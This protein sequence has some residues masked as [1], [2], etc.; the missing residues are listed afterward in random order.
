MMDQQRKWRGYNF[1]EEIISRV[2]WK[3]AICGKDHCLHS[4]EQVSIVSIR[5]YMNCQMNSSTRTSSRNAPLTNKQLPVLKIGI[6]ALGFR[7][8]KHLNALQQKKRELEAP[9]VG[10]SMHLCRKSVAALYRS[11]EIYP[12]L[13]SG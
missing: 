12:L 6:S 3:N 4:V 1:T 2:V 5:S 10:S 8:P 7:I 11:L 13:S 9:R